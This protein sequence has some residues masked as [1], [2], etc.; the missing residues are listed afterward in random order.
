M[1]TTAT[2][3]GII[4]TLNEAD[5]ITACI[6]SLQWTDGVV[7]LDS[8]STDATVE[9][10]QKAGA[11]IEVHPFENYAQQRNVALEIVEADWVLFVDAD[12]RATPDL[13]REVRALL[14]TPRQEAG[15]WIPRHN[16]IFGHRMRATGWFPDY[17]MRLLR[18]EAASYDPNRGVHEL[19]ELDGP[20]GYLKHPLIHYNY[21]TLRQFLEKQRRYLA[22]DIDVL[23][24]SG[25]QPHVYTPYTQALRHIWWRMV[26]LQGWKDTVWGLL[27]SV[28]MGYYELVKYR[29]VWQRQRQ[30]AIGR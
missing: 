10:A 9:L 4:L 26:T 6:E 18:R 25:V 21:K 5:H 20:E 24:E 7:V 3:Q 30:T 27:L 11:Q 16:Y 8:H 17:Q 12:E 29:S 15:W 28:M 14:E 23:S 2:L 22:Y 19:A 13:A 1:R